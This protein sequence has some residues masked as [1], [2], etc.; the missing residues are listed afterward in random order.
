METHVSVQHLQE[1]AK[2]HVDIKQNKVLDGGHQVVKK[3][4]RPS[5][6][7]IVEFFEFNKA[8]STE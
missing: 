6:S 5:P 7:S 3:R 2:W 1:L 8:I 4:T